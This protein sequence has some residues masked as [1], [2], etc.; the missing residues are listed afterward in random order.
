MKEPET[1]PETTHAG[2][3]SRLRQARI[4][5]EIEPA[6]IAEHLHMTVAVV[7]ALEQDNYTNLPT[8]VFVRGYIR[9]YA[10]LVD[11]PVDEVLAEFDQVWPPA[12]RPMKIQPPPRLAADTYPTHRGRQLVTWLLLL[13]GTVLFLLWWQGYL[14][15][16]W[17]QY[18]LLPASVNQPLD[19]RITSPPASSPV[20]SGANAVPEPLFQ[21][22]PRPEPVVIP[23]EPDS[24]PAS[25]PVPET[26]VEDLTAEAEDFPTEPPVV[27]LRFTRSSWVDIR[28]SS[29]TYQLTGHMAAGE[30]H[31][32][33]G[34]TPYQLVIG[35]AA[36]A[37]LSIDG[38]PYDMSPHIRSNVA[39]FTLITP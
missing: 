8:R 28:D 39:R 27:T 31:Q 5:Q 13:L 32:L 29:G 2:P 30:Q 16:A 18:T 25:E 15:Q 1:S 35:N 38:Q 33:G 19:T 9:N 23:E 6:T 21:P 34:S 12:E 3:G 10:R 24:T 17:Q 11:E 20:P 7:T 26:T 36:A 37:E 22:A 4:A 14:S